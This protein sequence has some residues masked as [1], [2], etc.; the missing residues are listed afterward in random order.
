[1]IQAM[2]YI[3]KQPFLTH[4]KENDCIIKLQ[5]IIHNMKFKKGKIFLS[6]IIYYMK[7]V[8]TSNGQNL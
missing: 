3:A 6:Q 5:N 2:N 1:M 7:S 8:Q 4:K